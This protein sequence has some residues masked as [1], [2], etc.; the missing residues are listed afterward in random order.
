LRAMKSYEKLKMK[1]I[2]EINGGE[3]KIRKDT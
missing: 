2:K 3:F 1:K